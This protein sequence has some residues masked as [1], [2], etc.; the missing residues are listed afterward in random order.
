MKQI[1]WICVVV[2]TLI[3]SYT[4]QAFQSEY[5]QAVRTKALFIVLWPWQTNC[6]CRKLLSA[7][8]ILD[9]V[10]HDEAK[11]TALYYFIPISLTSLN[12]L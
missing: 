1:K 8:G 9:E 5:N 7:V 6:S 2:S 11:Q 12:L 3:H 10:V 4:L